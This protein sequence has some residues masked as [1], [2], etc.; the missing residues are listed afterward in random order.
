VVFRSPAPPIAF[1]LIHDLGKTGLGSD[2][3]ISNA[4]LVSMIGIGISV[5]GILLNSIQRTTMHPAKIAQV[6][7]GAIVKYIILFH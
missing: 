3:K 7:T 2:E 5:A 1:Q 4:L 6:A